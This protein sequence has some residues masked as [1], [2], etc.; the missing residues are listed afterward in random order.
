MS[1]LDTLWNEFGFLPLIY[2]R[3]EWGYARV[4]QIISTR[5]ASFFS[6]AEEQLEYLLS[7]ATLIDSPSIAPKPH[8]DLSL[9]ED[10]LG[11]ICQNQYLLYQ[12]MEQWIPRVDCV[13]WQRDLPVTD[14]TSLHFDES[15]SSIGVSISEKGLKA[16]NLNPNC[17][18]FNTAVMTPA[19]EN[20]V[21]EI[22]LR[23]EE[24]K[25]GDE[26]ICIGLC[27]LP[28]KDLDFEESQEM[29]VYRCYNGE[30]YAQGR[31]LDRVLEQL[32][33]G[34]LVSGL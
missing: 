17:M 12:L 13:H 22:C 11:A 16:T 4:L 9:Y 26:M 6:S 2:N 24:D 3:D 34:E 1:T 19:L 14:V 21:Y 7:L 20:G 15:Y 27:C 18:K 25:T 23:V 32:H 29:W 31:R 33:K 28:L 5:F 8:T 30:C 10:L